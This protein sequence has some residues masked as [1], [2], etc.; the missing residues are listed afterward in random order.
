[1]SGP[2][3]NEAAAKAAVRL[4]AAPPRVARLSRVAI[5]GLAGLGAAGIGAALALA[6]Q[7]RAPKPVVIKTAETDGRPPQA[8]IAGPR[9]YAE[10]PKLGPPLPGDL[11]RPILAAQ[12][13]GQTVQPPP[14]GPGPADPTTDARRQA[15]AAARTSAVFSR[16]SPASPQGPSPPALPVTAPMPV[17]APFLEQPAVSDPRR[18]FLEARN[19]PPTTSAFRVQPPAG[20]KILIAQTVVPAALLTAVSSDLPGPVSAQVTRNVYDS[21]TGRT[22]LIPQGAK[23]IGS[24]DSQVAFG[25]K[26]VLLAWDR[27]VFPDGRSLQLDRLVGADAA[28]RSGLV[29]KTDA[30]WGAM[31]KAA[32]LSS[33]LGVGAALGSDDDGDIA[34]ALRQGV[35]DTVNQTGQQV[36]RKQL[37]V[38]PTLSL[39][40]GLPLT[41]LVTRD[42][43]FDD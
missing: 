27:V 17:S 5:A 42:I 10:I 14:I 12:Q 8:V 23:L 40:A 4:R 26:R 11:G 2:D 3:P 34:R 31:G 41:I 9:T 15:L 22:V 29:D 24:Y 32:V 16:S 6:L 20:R 43:V 25:Q 30:H 1:M 19:T 36:V 39:R 18:T 35:Q 33:V 13:R 21:L 38:Q 7:P 37:D 28:G